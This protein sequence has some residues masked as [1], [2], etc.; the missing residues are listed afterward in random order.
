MK[1]QTTDCSYYGSESSHEVIY[2][3]FYQFENELEVKNFI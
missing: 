3:F 2:L 1:P